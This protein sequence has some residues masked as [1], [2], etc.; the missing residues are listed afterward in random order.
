MPHSLR[1]QEELKNPQGHLVRDSEEASRALEWVHHLL[2]KDEE[3][4]DSVERPEKTDKDD[5]ALQI[6]PETAAEL[7]E[8][9]RSYGRCV[10][11]IVSEPILIQPVV[12]SPS[13]R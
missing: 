13:P 11:T 3:I 4:G 2:E 8:M 5:E 12:G 9:L 7:G 10:M 1:E 6:T